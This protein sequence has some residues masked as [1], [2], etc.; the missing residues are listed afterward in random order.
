[1]SKLLAVTSVFLEDGSVKR[2][3][4]FVNSTHIIAITPFKFY[5]EDQAWQDE[6][7]LAPVS[8]IE[9]SSGRFVYAAESAYQFEG[10]LL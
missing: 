5:R 6:P 2:E 9:L 8:V 7:D 10:M 4:V 1:M 3:R